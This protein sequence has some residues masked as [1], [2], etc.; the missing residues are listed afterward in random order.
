MVEAHRLGRLPAVAGDL[1]LREGGN[2]TVSV[3]ELADRSGSPVQRV[4]RVL[5]AAG[6]PADASTQLPDDL[7]ALMSAFD[8]GSNLMGEEAILAFTR[9]LGASAN[10]I[11][12]AAVALFYAQMGPGTER[13]GSDELG[14][15]QASEAATLAF[16]LVP[17]VLSHI[18]LAQFERASRR[19]ATIRGW[20]STDD[21][22][23]RSPSRGSTETVALGFVDLVGSTRWAQG[24]SLRDY[25]LALARFESASWS[26]AVLGGGRVVKMIGDEVFFAAPSVDA[27]CHIGT[28][29]C[30]A[31]DKDPVLPS[32]RGAVGFGQVTPREG[33][34]FGPLVH[35]LSRL[36]KVAAP[37]QVVVTEP[38]AA[39]VTADGWRFEEIDPGPIP[40]VEDPGRVFT[41]R[42]AEPR[43]ADP[44]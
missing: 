16:S 9:V 11:S 15:A 3:A 2:E 29:L 17:G 12:E 33:D 23:A 28:D 31:A 18:L 24:L 30:R 21:A 20:S 19:A 22:D 26:I 34:Y 40:G 10:T 8:A 7:V 38:A 14:R 6:L 44:R 32:A 36:T 41:I 25:S 1:L 43:V 39:S 4:E 5:L 42:G 35:L 37:G 27:A 13:E